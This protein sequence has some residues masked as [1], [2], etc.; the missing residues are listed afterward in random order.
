[1]IHR[2]SATSSLWHVT[3]I[4]RLGITRTQASGHSAS[5]LTLARTG[6][7]GRAYHMYVTLLALFSLGRRCSF[8]LCAFGPATV[9]MSLLAAAYQ[10]Q[11]EPAASRSWFLVPR[12]VKGPASPAV[13]ADSRSG[14]EGILNKPG[15]FVVPEAKKK[16]TY[17][18]GGL[19][20]GRRSQPKEF[21]MAK[22]GII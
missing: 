18:N 21:T 13:R 8:M 12:A 10:S 2:H 1:M 9:F 22:A 11:C 17:A 14:A 5:P 7:H 16:K 3:T 20:K 19:S 15:A 4:S 6:R